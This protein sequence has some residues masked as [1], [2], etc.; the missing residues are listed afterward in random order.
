MFKENN[1]NEKPLKWHKK[2]KSWTE[3][4]SEKEKIHLIWSVTVAF[5]SFNIFIYF[6]AES[7]IYLKLLYILKQI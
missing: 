5:D 4:I 3:Q 1:F 6:F 7:K 2:H